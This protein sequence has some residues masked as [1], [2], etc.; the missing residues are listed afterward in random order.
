M[1]AESAAAVHPVGR[2]GWQVTS[3][4]TQPKPLPGVTS[5]ADGVFLWYTSPLNYTAA[6]LRHTLHYD[7]T[8]GRSHC[9]DA[10][11]ASYAVR[12]LIRSMTRILSR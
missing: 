6:T 12:A 10:L 4:G 7:L 8:F 1:S 2:A 3:L 9:A 5:A 11:V